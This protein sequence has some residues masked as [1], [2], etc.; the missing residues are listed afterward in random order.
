M[1]CRRI[2]VRSLR[3]YSRVLVLVRNIVYLSMLKL[4]G[5]GPLHAGSDPIQGGKAYIRINVRSLRVYSR[6]LVSV[7]NIVYLSMLKLLE[8]LHAGLGPIQG[9][10]AYIRINVRSLRSISFKMAR[11]VDV[12][13]MDI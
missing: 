3:V 1:Y 4:P 5:T 10:K 12:C 6:V 11:W 7:R 8:T 2:N 9:G 13:C